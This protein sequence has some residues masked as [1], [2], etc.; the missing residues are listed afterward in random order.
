MERVPTA[1]WNIL[2]ARDA[3]TLMFLA[4][5]RDFADER[6][7]VFLPLPKGEGWGEG[8][9][10]M[11]NFTR[12]ANIARRS[13]SPLIPLPWERETRHS[14]EV[15]IKLLGSTV[16]PPAIKSLRRI[17][18][19]RHRNAPIAA[20]HAAEHSFGVEGHRDVS[21]PIERDQST[22]ATQVFRLF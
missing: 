12:A 7:Q 14:A 21:R 11:K 19:N 10:R 22:G 8:E 18:I 9:E 15:V 2:R 20:Q 1:R 13:P 6:G 4:H 16:K 5:R 3:I 17:R